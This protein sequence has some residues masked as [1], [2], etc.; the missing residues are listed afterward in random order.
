MIYP[1]KLCILG[2]FSIGYAFQITQMDPGSIDQ[3]SV[4]FIIWGSRPGKFFLHNSS[5]HF[6]NNIFNIFS[7]PNDG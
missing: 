3:L 1:N 2:L 6:L 5:N 7:S 4:W